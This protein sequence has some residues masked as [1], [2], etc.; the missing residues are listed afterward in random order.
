MFS[1]S[2]ERRVLTTSQTCTWAIRKA[3]RVGIYGVLKREKCADDIRKSGI[4]RTET[5]V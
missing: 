2:S 1:S 4:L 5:E 3:K